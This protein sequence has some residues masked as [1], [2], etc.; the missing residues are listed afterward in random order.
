MIHIFT[1]YLIDF[2][3]EFFIKHWIAKQI[4]ISTTFNHIKILKSIFNLPISSN[5]GNLPIGYQIQPTNI[6]L[7]TKKKKTQ[8]TQ[9]SVPFSFKNVQQNICQVLKSN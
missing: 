3:I 1:L 2:K 6:I 9:N 8:L 7:G 5:I 4:S